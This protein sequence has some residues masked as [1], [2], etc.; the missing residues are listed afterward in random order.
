VSVKKLL[1][2]LAYNLLVDGVGLVFQLFKLIVGENS[3]P[4]AD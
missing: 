1:E 3:Q 2:G 4:A